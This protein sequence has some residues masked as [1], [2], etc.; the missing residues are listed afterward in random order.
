MNCC[1]ERLNKITIAGYGL[2][3]GFFAETFC[4][5]R[6]QQG[7]GDE[8]LRHFADFSSIFNLRNLNALTKSKYF[9]L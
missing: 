6:N 1:C 5:C 7:N 3:K 8:D 4:A 9:W 2:K